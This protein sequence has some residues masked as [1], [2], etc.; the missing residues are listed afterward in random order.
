MKPS[1]AAFWLSLPVALAAL[2]PLAV[3]VWLGFSAEIAFSSRT[4]EILLNTVLLTVLSVLGCVLIGVPLAFITAYANLPG[5]RFWFAALAAP[6]AMPSYIGAFTYFAAFGAGG[7]LDSLLGIPTP[8]MEGLFGATLMLVL[9]SYPFV[10]LTTR[11]S[12]RNL[13]PAMV[14]AARVLG[15]SLPQ[16]LW[17][18]VLPRARAGIAAGS[19]IVAL[20][21]LSDFGTPAIMRLDTFT[22]MIYVEYNAFG[23]ERAALLSVYLLALVVVVLWLESR[24][25]HEREQPGRSLQISFSPLALLGLIGGVLLILLAA[26]GLPLG[27]FGVWLAREGSSGFDPVYAWNSIHA[28]L[29]A[30]LVAVIVALPVAYAAMGGK[31]GRLLERVTYLGFG[32]PGIVLGTALVYIG[33]QFDLLYQT[34]ALLVI[35]YVL[36]FLSLAVGA[37]RS[38]SERLDRNLVAAAR[39]LGASPLE[40][41]RRISLPLALPGIAAGAA[42]V[43][44]EAMRELPATLMLQPTGFDTLAT[45]LW[46][47]YESG[48]VGYGAI[49]GMLLVFVSMV[50]LVILLAGEERADRKRAL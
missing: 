49:P 15:M 2:A 25:G 34:L 24:V 1:R 42:L 5:R 28:S 32:V 9:Y 16:A 39:C 36:R 14:D 26:L 46:R 18:V 47:V 40:A 41:F 35:G 44:L 4:L 7:E 27:M 29:L 21:A 48:Y 50:A 45:Y 22:R 17:H 8:R 10:M 31:A 12:L 43:F 20:Y 30:A 23:L 37:I 6:L 11:A 13:D 38:R 33:L 3:L 19:L